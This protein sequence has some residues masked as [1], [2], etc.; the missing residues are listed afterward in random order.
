MSNELHELTVWFEGKP[1]RKSNSRRIFRKGRGVRARPFIAKSKLAIQWQETAVAKTAAW[2][3]QNLGSPKAPLTVTFFVWYENRLP[4][5]SIELALD[6]LEQAGI[7]SNDR[8]VYHFQAWKLFSTHLQGVYA[9]IRFM[10]YENLN[11]EVE[12]L[13]RIEQGDKELKEIYEKTKG[14]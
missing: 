3:K 4:D 10:R 9:I 13:Q 7:I 1:P 12:V 2:K 11:A 6:A 8:H 5:L 14:G